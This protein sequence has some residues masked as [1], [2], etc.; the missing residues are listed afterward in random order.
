MDTD[1][2]IAPSGVIVR[3]P[4]QSCP[5]GAKGLFPDLENLMLFVG[6]YG[7]IALTKTCKDCKLFAERVFIWRKLC[8]LGTP[9]D[10]PLQLEDN[11]PR[12]KIVAILRVHRLEPWTRLYDHTSYPRAAALEAR[13][14][15]N[16]INNLRRVGLLLPEG[17]REAFTTAMEALDPAAANFFMACDAAIHSALARVMS[18]EEREMFYNAIQPQVDI[19]LR[20]DLRGGRYLAR[21]PNREMRIFEEARKRA[22][23]RLDDIPVAGMAQM[24][25]GIIGVISPD[26]N[27]YI[28]GP[29]VMSLHPHIPRPVAPVVQ[30]SSR[31][32]RPTTRQALVVTVALS[33]AMSILYPYAMR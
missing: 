13:A 5:H 27:L 1:T 8:Q 32:R 11:D 4:A 3:A 24:E 29:N 30:R 17:A 14:K 7:T 22:V 31:C 28:W 33:V 18:E 20:I 23:T 15:E 2:K 9:T 10:D 25:D 12:W 6:E 16:G 19:I 21:E 26:G